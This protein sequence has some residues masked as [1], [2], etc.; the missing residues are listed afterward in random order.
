MSIFVIIYFLFYYLDIFFLFVSK[1]KKKC[2]N[3]K[4]EIYN[5][6]YRQKKRQIIRSTRKCERS[7]I[8]ALRVSILYL[9]LHLSNEFW[10][11]SDSVVYFIFH[12]ILS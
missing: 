12:F 2:S 1:K 10:N 6:K 3:N 8:C 11:C 9:F 5:D 7:C 4:K